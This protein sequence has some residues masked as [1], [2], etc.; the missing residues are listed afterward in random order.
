M[1]NH[2]EIKKRLIEA[3][4][5]A[6]DHLEEVLKAPILQEDYEGDELGPEKYLSAL[7]AKKQCQLDAFEMLRN[8]E[9]AQSEI[10]LLNKAVSK[11]Q[12]KVNESAK[13]FAETRSK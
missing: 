10:D 1:K 6:I 7:K 3:S 5:A 2:V 8:I 4:Y 11:K 9:A 12:D 13:G